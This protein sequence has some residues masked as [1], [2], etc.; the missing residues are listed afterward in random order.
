MNAMTSQITAVCSGADQRKHKSSVSPTFVR[1]IHQWPV[2]FPHEGTVTRKM[3]AFDEATAIHGQTCIM[4][5]LTH[6]PLDKMAAILADDISK[7]IF[8]NENDRIPIQISLKFVSRSP[9]DIK[10]ALVQI[11][12][13]RRIGDKP[14]SEPI[15]TQFTDAYIRH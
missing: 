15:L 2:D 11:M 6:L 5:C 13:W 10:P 12:A 3:F 1:G 14:L 8:L 4:G 9:I 7:C